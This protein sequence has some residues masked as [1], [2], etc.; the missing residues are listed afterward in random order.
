M[1]Q[2]K[3]ISDILKNKKIFVPDYQ[4]SY[5]WDT[6]RPKFY[7]KTHVDVFL[8]DVAEYIN[9]NSD[10]NYYLGHFI[11][12]FRDNRGYA[13]IDG[14]Q[15]LTTIIILISAACSILKDQY[16]SDSAYYE[17][18]KG[19]STVDY[20]DQFFKDYVI[21]KIKK[22]QKK[23][24]TVS[25][26]RIKLAFDY[27][28]KSLKKYSKSEI[29]KLIDAL[30][31]ASCTA[32]VVKQESESVQMFIFQNN[33]GKQPSNLEIIKAMFMYNVHLRASKNA[34]TINKEIKNRFEKIYKSIAE[35]EYSVHEDDILLY[36]LRV[37]FNSLSEHMV[38]IPFLVGLLSRD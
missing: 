4:R 5:S 28:K 22:N 9:S 12:E 33:R 16:T 1:K 24:A 36:T 20:D 23:F 15:R 2:V 13:I 27:Y 18:L 29:E 19:F 14:Q 17:L 31:N 6:P 3:S 8:D 37:Y 26:E 25:E 11:F 34:D 10:S 21:F 32:H 30:M 7:S 35:I 38:I